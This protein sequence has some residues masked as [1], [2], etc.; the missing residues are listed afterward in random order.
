MDLS[1]V[2]ST[3]LTEKPILKGIGLVFI[4]WQTLLEKEDCSLAQINKEAT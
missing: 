3:S 2:V 1:I 4:Q